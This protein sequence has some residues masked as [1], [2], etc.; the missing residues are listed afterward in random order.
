M[1]N[2]KSCRGR[3]PIFTAEQKRVLP[4]FISATLKKQLKRMQK[5]M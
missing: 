1:A 3:K 5:A 4:K 2:R